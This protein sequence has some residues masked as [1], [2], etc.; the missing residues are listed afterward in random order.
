MHSIRNAQSHTLIWQQQQLH[1]RCYELRSGTVLCA[2]LRWLRPV[3]SLAQADTAEGQWTFKRV[4]FWRPRVTVRIHAATTDLLVFEPTRTGS[5]TLDLPQ[6]RQLRWST[7]AAVE[8][9]W[10]WHASTGQPLLRFATSADGT[11]SS[12]QVTIEPE[13]HQLPDLALL[14]ALGWYLTVLLADDASAATEPP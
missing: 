9:R 12:G 3:G 5:G 4:G 2:T 10:A 13:A 7:T 1:P 14:V 8:S 11:T 6:A